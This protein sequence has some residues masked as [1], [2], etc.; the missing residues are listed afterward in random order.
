[1]EKRLEGIYLTIKI[2]CG[3]IYVPALFKAQAAAGAPL[4]ALHE[5]PKIVD[6]LSE[7][8]A[9]IR[10]TTASNTIW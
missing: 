5:K 8:I 4:P 2:C 6:F 9:Y 3:R 1:M 7:V 10:F